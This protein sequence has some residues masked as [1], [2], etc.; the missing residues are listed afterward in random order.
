MVGSF[1]CCR[2]GSAQSE[3]IACVTFAPRRCCDGSGDRAGN[4]AATGLVTGLVKDA[5]TVSCSFFP[6]L[7]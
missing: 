3:H 4:G 7:Q 5:Q 6:S 1:H 2:N